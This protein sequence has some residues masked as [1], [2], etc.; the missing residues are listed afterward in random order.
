MGNVCGKNDTETETK[1][2]LYSE[3]PDDYL[4][5]LFFQGHSSDINSICVDECPKYTFDVVKISVGSEASFDPDQLLCHD[6]DKF[7]EVYEEELN[8]TRRLWRETA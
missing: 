3:N 5:S 2:F 4:F 1:P 7:N 8:S 6:M